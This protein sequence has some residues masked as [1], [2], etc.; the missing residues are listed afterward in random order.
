MQNSIPHLHEKLSEKR[1]TLQN[2]SPMDEKIYTTPMMSQW[3]ACKQEA[4]EAL[5]LFR[6][7]DFYESFCEDAQIIAKEANLTLT[8]RQGVPMCGMPFHAAESY[9]D[10]L[11]AKGFKVAIAEQEENPTSKGLMKRE[12]V[13]IVT[14]GTLLQSQLLLDKRPNF[15]AA[16]AQVGSIYGLTL[17]DLTTT[18]LRVLEFETPSELA[19]E[20]CRTKPSELLLSQKFQTHHALLLQ[21]LSYRFAYLLNTK[22]ESYFQLDI[23]GQALPASLYEQLQ[24][25]VAAILSSGILIVYLQKELKIILPSLSW[26]QTSR[27]EKFLAIDRATLRHLELIEPLSDSSSHSTLLKLLDRTSTPMGGRLLRDWIQHP[28]TSLPDITARQEAITSFFTHSKIHD[29]IRILLDDIRDLERIM[30][31]LSIGSKTPRDLLALGLSLAQ[32]TPLREALSALPSKLFHLPEDSLKEFSALSQ[33]I[34]HSFVETPPLKIGDGELFRSGVDPELDRLR[35]LAK[36]SLQWMARY[37][38]E[39]REESG[40]KTLKVGFTR[41]FGYYIEVSAGQ[42]EK[43]PSSFQRRQTLT[44]A[45]RFTTDTLKQFEY[46][47]LSAEERSQAL[48]IELFDTLRKEALQAKDAI[49]Q[50]ARIIAQIDLL[51]SLARVAKDEEWIRPT[52]DLSTDLFIE[53]GRHPILEKTIGRAHFIANDT[54]LSPPVSQ[55]MLITGP[56]MA[57]K[58]TYLRQVALLV[59]LAQMGS[60]IPARAARIGLVDKIF[61]RI[62]ASD[63]LT[64]GHSTFMVEM[65]ETAHILKE[66]TSRSLIVLDEIGR[67]TSTYDGIAIAWA[68]AEFLL[69]TPG[70][71]AKTLFATH[72][73]ELTYLEKQLEGAVNYQVAIQET[74]SGAVFLRKIIPGGTHKSYGIHVAKLAGLPSKAI[75]R[76]EEVLMQLEESSRSDSRSDK[77]KRPK[78]SDA[79]LPLFS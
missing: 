20:L 60:F 71:K 79:Q 25:R 39:L 28:L 72:Y 45:E 67:G 15:F 61:S 34:L 51:C 10:R 41:A 17:L 65:S 7:G 3:H 12:I 26:T 59:I 55:L 1:G 24:G 5:L 32:I 2:G 11:I 19:D 22:E 63:D 14:P 21:E 69:T 62:G 13:R 64:R 47:I 53:G 8:A 35:S 42:K 33:K 52:L 48:E 58:S 56:N 44:H 75:Q 73:W 66:A 46:Q 68:V 29:V 9:I 38:A 6:L 16:I 49:C 23:A 50:T 37:Q 36:E 77:G 76:A 40:I 78:K 70:Q 43:V 57:G 74:G 4:K 31:R 30:V 18:E 27:E 54:S